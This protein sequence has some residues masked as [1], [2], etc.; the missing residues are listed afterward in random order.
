MSERKLTPEEIKELFAFCCK[1]RVY[2]YDLQIELID[3]LA[4]SIENYWIIEPEISFNQ[5]LNK[6]YK[7][8]GENGFSKIKAEKEKALRKKYNRLLW[9][10]VGEYF[11]LPKIILT[12]AISLVLFTLLQFSNIQAFLVVSYLILFLPFGLIYYFYLFPKYFQIKVIPGKSFLLINYLKKFDDS[13]LFMSW[14]PVNSFPFFNLLKH[15][16]NSWVNLLVAVTL[17]FVT[18]VVYASCFFV[19]QK[20]REHF[21]REFPQFVKS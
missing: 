2:Q 10:F 21:T 14:I 20:V 4:S 8:F 13:F 12:I 15:T 5:A 18:I 17:T 19:P 16:N 1:H 6:T 7:S 3:H 11:K 9:R